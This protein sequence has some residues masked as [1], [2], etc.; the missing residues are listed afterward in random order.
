VNQFRFLGGS[1]GLAIVGSVM[2]SWSKSQFLQILTPEQVEA[3]LQTT[4]VISSF[5]PQIQESVRQILAQ[6]YNLQMRILIGL[7]AA[8]FPATALMWQKKP[9]RLS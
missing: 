4:T 9:I 2:Y 3:L 6:G 5:T 7:A 1:I 8:Q